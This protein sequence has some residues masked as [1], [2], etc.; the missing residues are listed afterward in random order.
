MASENI[1]NQ[2]AFCIIL[3]RL[4][5]MFSRKKSFFQ[6]SNFIF[7][8]RDEKKNSKLNNFDENERK[9]RLKT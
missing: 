7:D 4:L 5:Q 6:Q 8:F 1:H 2:N 3:L 9:N